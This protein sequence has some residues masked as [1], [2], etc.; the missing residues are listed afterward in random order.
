[1]A[2]EF[3]ML[4]NL[5]FRDA[6]IDTDE[7]LMT[8][9]NRMVAK[10]LNEGTLTL[11]LKMTLEEKAVPED[12][13]GEMTMGM[14][15]TLRYKASFAISESDSIDGGCNTGEFRILREKGICRIKSMSDDQ[16]SLFDPEE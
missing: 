14:V 6:L 11:K 9:L 12:G 16:Q 4:G 15:P 8:M 7:A 3:M 10:G 5:M 2:N 13:T 1:M